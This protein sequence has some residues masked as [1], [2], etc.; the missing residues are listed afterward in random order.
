MFAYICV[1][2]LVSYGTT[3]AGIERTQALLGVFVAAVV[4]VV[5]YPV[6]GA[7]SDAY[8]RKPVFLAGVVLMGLSVAPAFALINTGNPTLF[9]AALLLVFGFAMAPAAGVTGSLFSLAFDA[10]VRYSGVSIGYT[11]SQVLGSA[12]APTIAT[13][14]YAATKTSNSIVAYLIAVSVISAVSACF[15]PGRWR[16]D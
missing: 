3:V 9:L 12:F 1:A 6:F 2:Y 15:L 4:A 11:L 5:T 8:G 10:D 14:L 16:R 13:A 7:L